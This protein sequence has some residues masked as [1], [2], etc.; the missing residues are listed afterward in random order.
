MQDQNSPVFPGET[1]LPPETAEPGETVLPPETAEREAPLPGE[2]VAPEADAFPLPG[3]TQPPEEAPQA[4]A[5]AP[6]GAALKPGT[7]IDGYVIVSLI[8]DRGKQSTVYLARKSGRQYALKL[9]R[10]RMG[11]S[12]AK[13]E[14]LKSVDSPYVAALRDYGTFGNLPYEVYDYY[15]NGTVE[16]IGKVETKRLTRFADQLNEGLHALHTLGGHAMVHGDLKPANIFL[17]DDGESLLIGDFGVSAALNNESF[18]IVPACGTPEFAPPTLSVVNRA[19]RTPAFDYGALGLVIYF[20][21]TGRSYFSGMR[22]DEIAESWL[23]GIQIPA[24][25]DTRV[26]MLLEGLLNANEQNRYGYNE[27]RD[28]VR[29]SFVHSAEP[30]S[31]FAEEKAPVSAHLWF[32]ILDGRNINVT[33]VPELVTCMKTYWDQAKNKLRDANLY[34]FL[35]AAARDPAAAKQVRRIADENPPDAAVF[36]TLYYLSQDADIVY[37]G[38][39]YGD[40]P[41]FV[42]QASAAPTAEIREVLFT[43]LFAYYLAQLG[44]SED[45]VRTVEE[46]TALADVSERFRLRVFSWVFSA[47]KEYRGCRDLDALRSMI[48]GK[49]LAEIDGIANDEAFIAWLY[50]Q[51]DRTLALAMLRN[52]TEVSL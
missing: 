10:R 39:N 41:A 27:V 22:P 20:L 1:F 31:V 28:W 37:K 49:E 52:T 12:P 19:K 32:G 36:K 14:T 11:V 35:L 21:A 26:K 29:G 6:G 25:L 16:N 18:S 8:S 47:D 9:F 5:A 3:E 42:K 15:K 43:G 34:K 23:R 2:T 24:E 4:P 51:G 13:L 7:M 40:A 45:M 38:V 50:A 30:T 44:Y 33:S 48:A 17:S 46:I